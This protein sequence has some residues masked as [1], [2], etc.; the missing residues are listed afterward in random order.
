MNEWFEQTKFELSRFA[1]AIFVGLAIL[2]A[3]GPD[4]MTLGEYGRMLIVSPIGAA[5]GFAAAMRYEVSYILFAG[6]LGVSLGVPFIIGLIR[7]AWAFKGDPKGFLKM[8][9]KK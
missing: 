3:V 1:I 5:I 6:V 4:R 8:W 2:I 9:R 7:L